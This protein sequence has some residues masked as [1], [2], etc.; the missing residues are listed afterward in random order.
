M[1]MSFALSLIPGFLSFLKLPMYNWA[2]KTCFRI[3][4]RSFSGVIQFHNK[5]HRPK[6]DGICVAN[7]T[8][9]IDVVVLSC[10]RSYALV[11]R[12]APSPC[13]V[14]GRAR[15]SC[16]I[17]MKAQ[18]NAPY[19]TS[20]CPWN[21]TNWDNVWNYSIL[22]LLFMAMG[23]AFVGSLRDSEFKRWLH[24]QVYTVSFQ[25]LGGA[26]SVVIT[27]HNPE[28]RPKQGICVA[29]H[30]SPIDV[31]VLACDNAYAL[32]RSTIIPGIVQL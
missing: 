17:W 4:S 3:L 12:A 7:H 5:Q 11:G 28:N 16:G 20:P 31:L 18:R 30:T 8:T 24:D 26:L 1:V 13:W 9:P 15:F 29:N 21:V 19:L 6:S 10:D 25:I 23:L 27:Y 22:Q 32:V 14:R 2:A